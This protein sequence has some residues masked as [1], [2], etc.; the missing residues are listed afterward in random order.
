MI[1]FY[2]ASSLTR[3]FLSFLLGIAVL[4]QTLAI[5]INFYRQEQGTRR[6]AE[7]IF[8]IAILFE[9][10]IFGL[11]HGQVVNGFRY[12]LLVP[13]GY[14]RIRISAFLTILVLALL[15]FI[16]NK[17]LS[18]LIILVTTS[19]SLPFIERL[20]GDAFPWIFTTALLFILIRSIRLCISSLRAIRTRLSAL[21]IV[22]ALD[23]L[24]AGVVFCESD[25]YI[26]LSNHQMYDLMLIITG[27][28]FR[29]A[30]EFY[31]MLISD[32][33]ES[34]YEKVLLEGQVVYLLP[35]DTAWMFTKTDISLKLKNYVHISAVD[36]S[37]NWALTSKLQDQ[38]QELRKKSMEIKDRIS[39]LH[40]LSEEKEIEYAK[41]RAHDILG[42]R[43]T[44][45]LRMI[46]NEKKLDYDLLISLS[47]G[48]LDE[49]KSEDNRKSS[50]EELANI[51]EIFSLIGVAIDFQGELPKDEEQ[52][53]LFIDIIR[54]SSTNAVRH[55]FAT[56]IYIKSE[57]IGSQY[58]LTITNKGYTTSEPIIPGSGIKVMKKKIDKQG[59][60]LEIVS[61]PQFTLSVVLPGGE[62]GE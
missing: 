27:K 38:D 36:V 28:I 13:T 18:S 39:K 6:I 30:I 61:Y 26:L 20:I 31:Q 56:Q 35:D 5:V 58:K 4:A 50:L 51:Q 54:E 12:G 22:H 46:Q 32:K 19:I 11:L 1:E 41:M 7:N 44:V 21:S 29:N 53:K 25:G 17:N 3:I 62:E 59:G 55:G 47:R 37:E 45:I 16:L 40:I 23:T 9:I 43:L 33:Y 42:Q 24:P 2:S 8:E 57:L 49:L 60:N 15:V 14:E 10:F 52:A 34:R 48:L